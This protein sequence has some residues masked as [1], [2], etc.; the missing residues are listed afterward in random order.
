MMLWFNEGNYFTKKKEGFTKG[1]E[2]ITA[3]PGMHL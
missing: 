3:S 2:E 1:H